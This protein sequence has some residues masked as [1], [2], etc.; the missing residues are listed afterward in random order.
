PGRRCVPQLC[1]EPGEV[2]ELPAGCGNA[3][4]LGLIDEDGQDGSV[5]GRV[6][7]AGEESIP[8]GKV[9]GHSRASLARKKADPW[10]ARPG[11]IPPLVEWERRPTRPRCS[12]PAPP[13]PPPPSR[14]MFLLLC[15][16][17]LR[18]PPPPAPPPTPPP[19]SP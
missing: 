19:P 9:P 18:L 14:L 10:R 7:G 15:C 16:Q 12:P 1:G 2:A 3:L 5:V 4:R 11:G 6:H 8:R 17:P 13:P